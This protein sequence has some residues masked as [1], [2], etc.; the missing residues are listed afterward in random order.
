PS[1]A[2]ES[3]ERFSKHLR[4]RTTPQF[5]RVYDAKCRAGDGV[6]LVFGAPR[7]DDDPG[8]LYQG[9]AVS[10]V[11]LSVSK[12]NGNAVVRHRVKR[13]LREAFRTSKADLPAGWD[14]VLIP[15]PKTGADLPR[16]RKSLVKL[17]RRL[18]GQ[19]AKKHAPR[20]GANRDGTR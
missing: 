8:R 17:A 14:F 4:L 1:R 15:R 19:W 10:R 12:K 13:L 11:G 6:L 7:P 9:R 5:A 16:L 20:D 3:D 18:P 2:G